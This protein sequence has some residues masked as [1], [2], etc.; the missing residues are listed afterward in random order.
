MTRSPELSRSAALIQGRRE[1]CTR[2]EFR[3]FRYVKPMK[4]WAKRRLLLPVLPYPKPD[5]AKSA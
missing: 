4:K 1:E 2:H 3:Q 5:A